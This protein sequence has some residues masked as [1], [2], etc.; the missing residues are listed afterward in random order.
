MG[1]W[2]FSRKP[3]D[4]TSDPQIRG[5]R[6]WL[7][8][9]REV[10]ESHYDDLEN[11]QAAVVKLRDEW[12]AAATL[13]EVPRTLLTGLNKRADELLICDGGRWLELLD[14]ER[15]W[16]PGWRPSGDGDEPSGS[17]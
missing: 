6:A 5:T 12:V 15:F 16:K 1:W 17:T 2:P 7:D 8:D 10:C 9:L 14:S 4:T 13:G 11:G 3:V